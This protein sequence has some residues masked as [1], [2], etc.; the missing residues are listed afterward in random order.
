[1]NLNLCWQ[2][3]RGVPSMDGELKQFFFHPLKTAVLHLSKLPHQSAGKRCCQILQW[4]HCMEITCW[5]FVAEGLEEASG[6]RTGRGWQSGGPHLVLRF[7]GALVR[8]QGTSHP[9]VASRSGL[10]DFR[11]GTRSSY[12]TPSFALSFEQFSFVV[13]FSYFTVNHLSILIQ[14]CFPNICFIQL[15]KMPHQII[16]SSHYGW[17]WLVFRNN[18]RGDCITHAVFH[19]PVGLSSWEGDVQ[20]SFVFYW[21]F[22]APFHNKAGGLSPHR[23]LPSCLV[24]PI[25]PSRGSFPPPSPTTQ[26]CLHEIQRPSQQ[27][28]CPPPLRRVPVTFPEFKFEFVGPQRH[29]GAGFRFLYIPP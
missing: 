25:P 27:D 1:M 14:T 28:P 6:G 2:K 21:L 10:S 22:T 15:L 29:L 18:T 4:T 20:I 5:V 24:L 12:I 3:V 19:N 17:A 23:C 8:C 13:L 11:W 7:R 26:L 16:H 9:R